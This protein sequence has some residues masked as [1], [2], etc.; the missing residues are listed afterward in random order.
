MN[1]LGL[2]AS[3]TSVELELPP[4]NNTFV[5]STLS[6]PSAI[7][8]DNVNIKVTGLYG[9]PLDDG[10]RVNVHLEGHADRIAPAA[11][12]PLSMSIEPPTAEAS[13]YSLAITIRADGGIFLPMLVYVRFVPRSAKLI[14]TPPIIKREVQRGKSTGLDV[15]IYNG[16]DANSGPIDVLLPAGTFV[17]VGEELPLT[18]L[19]PGERTS[20]RLLVQPQQSQALGLLSARAVIASRTS[21]DTLDLRLTVVSN[22]TVDVQ[23]VV[24]DEF[25]YFAEGNPGLEGA[26]VRL[27]GRVLND[28]I[29]NTSNADGVAMFYG[30]REGAYEISAQALKHGPS[31]VVLNVS[32]DMEQPVRLFLPRAAISYVW[33]V[34]PTTIADTYTFELIAE[35][36]TFVPMPVVTIEPAHL[37]L[38]RLS[39]GDIDQIDFVITNHGLIAANQPVLTLPTNHPVV[40]FEQI[41]PN[42][43]LLPANSSIIYSVKVTVET[44]SL[45]PTTT[46]AGMTTSA[47]G[48]TTTS[49]SASSGGSTASSSTTNGG[50]TTTS[51]AGTGGQGSTTTTRAGTTT[52][53]GTVVGGST[54]VPSASTTTTEQATT[55]EP[56]ATTT[57]TSAGGSSSSTAA[58][59]TVQPSTTASDSVTAD[60]GGGDVGVCG[61]SAS[62]CGRSYIGALRYWVDAGGPKHSGVTIR[63]VLLL[64]FPGCPISTPSFLGSATLSSPFYYFLATKLSFAKS[65]QSSS[66]CLSTFSSRPNDN[67]VYWIP[68]S[69]SSQSS[70]NSECKYSDVISRCVF[71]GCTGNVLKPVY[72][73]GCETAND[74]GG[75]GGV[76]SDFLEAVVSCTIGGCPGAWASVPFCST[77]ALGILDCTSNLIFSCTGPYGAGAEAAAQMALCAATA[78]SLSRRRRDLDDDDSAES[79]P[80]YSAASP[81]VGRLGQSVSRRVVGKAAAPLSPEQH[82][83]QRRDFERDQ[84]AE[85]F[86]AASVRVANAI[87]LME[88]IFGRG[89]KT[90]ASAYSPAFQ[91]EAFLPAVLQGGPM[92]ELLT[93]AEKEHMMA[94]NLTVGTDAIGH[95]ADRWN[96][97]VAA[98]SRG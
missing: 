23:V 32:P 20:V 57:K 27:S 89:N 36:E 74:G 69:F 7:A 44:S 90:M 80:L 4:E 47:A 60:I 46:S 2:E 25:T 56:G 64:L 93:Q 21:Y 17:A 35:Y 86:Y 83:R 75:N 22:V 37:D 71:D 66:S 68:R 42:L 24:E 14:V 88:A 43:E 6:N 50:V 79:L 13:V 73:I 28:R 70:C 98:W 3:R 31:R 76:V 58:D 41:S 19:A 94:A 92:G 87:K 59:G 33:T 72:R 34:T 40:R 8:A 63:L 12:V 10:L 54:T 48:G 96:N 78:G 61:G 85:L 67:S 16:G 77:D 95:F 11:R 84:A 53:D 82:L 9:R 18:G 97:T 26:L 52:T 49:A 55:L 51:A 5:L 38:D 29:T 62:R 45:A 30:V 39:F 81:T 91:R 15:E 1:I 65:R